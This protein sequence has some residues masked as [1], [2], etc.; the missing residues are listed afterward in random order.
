MPHMVLAAD[1]D[2]HPRALN[3]F[4]VNDEVWASLVDDHSHDM[5]VG[6]LDENACQGTNICI[7]SRSFIDHL[8]GG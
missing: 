4:E 5:L 1:G 2:K 8:V 6:M 3:E 7:N